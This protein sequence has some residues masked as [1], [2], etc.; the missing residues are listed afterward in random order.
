MK[1]YHKYLKWYIGIVRKRLDNPLPAKGNHKHH[2]FPK[3]IYGENKFI[4]NLTYKEHFVSHRL[5]VKIM[6]NRYGVDS[7]NAFKMMKALGYMSRYF[8][9]NSLKYSICQ[10]HR[11]LS[12]L[13]AKNPMFGLK[14]SKEQSLKRSLRQIGNKNHNYG[15]VTPDSVK[16][17]LRVSHSGD[18]NHFFGKKHSASSLQKMAD[19]NSRSYIITF[20]NNE[21][22][23]IKNLND[24]CRK[25]FGDKWYTAKTNIH[26]SY[27]GY[28]V[29]KI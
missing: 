21:K 11:R 28:R 3:S 27:K 22:L 29:E 25:E 10:N 14:I 4:I 12:M 24:F 17:K 1:K 20:P 16:D 5:L 2:V 18:K 15:K 8:K 23:Q 9:D 13:G 7:D 6:E 19:K 26:K